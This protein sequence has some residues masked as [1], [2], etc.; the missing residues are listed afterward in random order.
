MMRI[1]LVTSISPRNIDRQAPAIESWKALGLPIV[2]LNAAEEVAAVRTSFP[3]ATI[4]PVDRSA[5]A[6]LGKPLVLLDSVWEFARRSAHDT[7]CLLN[8][9]M[10]LRDA[11]AFHAIADRPF[12]MI[13]GSRLDVA[14]ADDP[15]GAIYET[16]ID[17]FLIRRAAIDAYPSPSPF[18]LGAPWWD[19]WLP[20]VAIHA[21]Q[22]VLRCAEPLFAH[23]KHDT[24]WN[25]NWHAVMGLHVAQYLLEHYRARPKPQGPRAGIEE[26]F[27]EFFFRRMRSLSDVMSGQKK[28]PPELQ[29][30]LEDELIGAFLHAVL[31]YVR[32]HAD[33]VS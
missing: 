31:H 26:I 10:I 15:A 5:A 19:F 23:V 22:N 24:Q 16:G 8:S 13:F 20:M 6:A 4:E 32:T 9:D 33:P 3:D 11:A 1:V 7:I 21:G 12:D 25:M 2:S 28:M 18:C 14:H 29:S 17:Y 27:P 30:V